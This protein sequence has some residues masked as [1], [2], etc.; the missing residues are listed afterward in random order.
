MTSP[1][2]LFLKTLNF[3]AF[4]KVSLCRSR[5]SSNLENDWEASLS[6]L[7]GF[8]CSGWG[9]VADEAFSVNQFGI[10]KIRFTCFFS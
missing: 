1:V 10:L 6:P 9:N 8:F 7:S 5:F 3:R 2:L 4:F